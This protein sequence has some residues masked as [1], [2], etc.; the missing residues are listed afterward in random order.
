MHTGN[1]FCSAFK[2]LRASERVGVAL[3]PSDGSE[4]GNLCASSTRQA[5]DQVHARDHCDP[6]SRL[7]YASA[8]ELASRMLVCVCLFASELEANC[9]SYYATVY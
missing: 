2:L 4:N 3:A 1:R 9:I 6:R 7:Q 8:L 5:S